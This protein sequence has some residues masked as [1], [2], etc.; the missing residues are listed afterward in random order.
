MSYSIYIIFHLIG[1]F[2]VIF[3]LGGSLLQA[4]NTGNKNF[5]FKKVI[6]AVHGIG[7]LLL[8]VAGFGL[9]AK[10]GYSTIPLWV[11]IKIIIWGF[12][13]IVSGLAFKRAKESKLLWI[14]TLLLFIVV[15][16]LAQLKPFS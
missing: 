10:N 14:I 4:I 13:A 1:A 7:L 2:F 12:Y 6:G 11:W 16:V 5:Q 9:I 8:F 15:I 3:A